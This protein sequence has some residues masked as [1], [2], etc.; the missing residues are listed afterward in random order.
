MK[1]CGTLPHYGFTL[2]ELMIAV[3]IAG[4]L[5]A[6]AYPSYLESVRRTKRAEGKA[7]LTE[8]LLH[9]ERYYSQHNTYVEFSATSA[10]KDSFKW[11]SGG[12]AANSAY[13]LAATTCADETIVNCVNLTA[14]PGTVLVDGHFNDPKCGQLSMSSN[15]K[16]SPENAEC[17]K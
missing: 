5:A 2:I 1:N 7:A 16:R 12:S 14:K 9:Q 13:E 3:V 8:I 17:W 6:I 11:Y 15:G 4:I 10:N